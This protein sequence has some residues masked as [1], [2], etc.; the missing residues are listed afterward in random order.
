[1][2][3]QTNCPELLKYSYLTKCLS[4][5]QNDNYCELQKQY[6]GYDATIVV[7]PLDFRS[8]AGGTH[9]SYNA[10]LADLIWMQKYFNPN[11]R[12]MFHAEAGQ[13]DCFDLFKK[14]VIDG[15]CVGVKIYPPLSPELTH[16]TFLKIFSECEA[17]NI[18]VAAHCS[19]R[20]ANSG[21]VLCYKRGE[22]AHPKYWEPIL[23]SFPLLRLDFSHFGNLF[24]TKD[25]QGWGRDVATLVMR[26]QNTF[27]DIS[28]VVALKNRYH[29]LERLLG[30]FP[31]LQDRLLFGSDFYLSSFEEINM[32]DA[33]SN[34]RSFLGDDVFHLMTETNPL[35]WM[36]GRVL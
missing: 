32:S 18:P 19:P 5:Q 27:T 9:Y 10:Q 14:H 30:D 29:E 4:S 31:G 6:T 35:K 2:L 15:P 22:L 11:M 8:M 3:K 25:Q 7:I 20:G 33:V 17:R 13:K 26:Y 23:K 36:A 16:P 1:L 12:I 28:Y 21:T 34:I 24:G